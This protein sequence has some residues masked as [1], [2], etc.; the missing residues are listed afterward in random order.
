[1]YRRRWSVALHTEVEHLVSDEC[2]SMW[3]VWFSTARLNI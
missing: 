2:A 3:G 1:M